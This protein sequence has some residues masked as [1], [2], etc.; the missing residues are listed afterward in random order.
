MYIIIIIIIIMSSIIICTPIKY[1][2]DNDTEASYVA[3]IGGVKIQCQISVEKPEGKKP[4]GRR[5][6]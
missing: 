1:I 2:K 5:K 4:F 6:I 3:R